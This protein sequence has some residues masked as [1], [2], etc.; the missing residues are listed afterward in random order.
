MECCDF[1]LGQLTRLHHDMLQQGKGLG[2]ENEGII[3][4][5]LLNEDYA[6]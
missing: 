2:L 3:L 1:Q 4:H 6:A 5:V